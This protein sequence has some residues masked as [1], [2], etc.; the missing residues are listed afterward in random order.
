MKTK[1]ICETCGFQPTGYA[2]GIKPLGIGD[3]CVWCKR[4]RMEIKPTPK[5]KVKGK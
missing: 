4:G 1:L 3:I 5:P 2:K